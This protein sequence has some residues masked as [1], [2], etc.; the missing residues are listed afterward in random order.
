MV[1]YKYTEKFDKTTT[2]ISDA[3]RKFFD[4]RGIVYFEPTPEMERWL[5]EWVKNAT[6]PR[7]NCN[8]DIVCYWRYWGTWGKYDRESFSISVCPYRIEEAPGGLEGVIRH[9]IQHLLHPEADQMSHE[10][11][12]KYINN[13]EIQP[14]SAMIKG[15]AIYVRNR[16]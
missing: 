13:F 6:P 10:D 15:K 3:E 11:K 16:N 14:R 8:Q 4:D 2:I 7:K 1:K 5:K 12:E 9:E